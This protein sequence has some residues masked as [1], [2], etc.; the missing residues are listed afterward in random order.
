MGIINAGTAVGGVIAPPL[1]ALVLSSSD[2]RTVFYLTA[3]VG[4]VVVGLVVAR[5]SSARASSAARR[6]GAHARSR[7]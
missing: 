5:L 6:R 3:V 1:I 4:V 7:R 2:W